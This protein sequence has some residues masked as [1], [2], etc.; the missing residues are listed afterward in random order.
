MRLSSASRMLASALSVVSYLLLTHG[1][2]VEGVS[3]NLVV[4]LLLVPFAWQTGAYDMI[5][6]SGVFG[7]IN[8]QTL[9]THIPYGN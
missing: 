6:L 9:F 5:T 3:I 2:A 7:V 4:Q 1:H 8:L